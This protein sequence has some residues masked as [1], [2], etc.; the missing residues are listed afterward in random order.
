[1]SAVCVG[2][3]LLVKGSSHTLHTATVWNTCIDH[4]T[5]FLW[6][7]CNFPADVRTKQWGSCQFWGCRPAGQGAGTRGGTCRRSSSPA[8]R[9]SAS[10]PWTGHRGSGALEEGESRQGCTRSVNMSGWMNLSVRVPGPTTR[11]SG[12]P[13]PWCSGS[14]CVIPLPAPTHTWPGV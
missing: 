6:L 13:Q 12:S 7:T 3:L 9:T 8:Q 11:R 5:G 1:M 10:H 4:L 14:A 2:T